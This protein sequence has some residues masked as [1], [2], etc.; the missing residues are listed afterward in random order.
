M[1]RTE[2]SRPGTVLRRT[3]YQPSPSAGTLPLSWLHLTALPGL[4]TRNILELRSH[5]LGGGWDLCLRGP[6]D[7]PFDPSLT[8]ELGVA[9]EAEAQRVASATHGVLTGLER[10]TVLVDEKPAPPPAAD[11]AAPL[12]ADLH[13]GFSSM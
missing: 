10:R 7:S 9:S 4:Y 1:P 5:P 3:Q 13:Q 11:S 2:D 12:L 8:L 6:E